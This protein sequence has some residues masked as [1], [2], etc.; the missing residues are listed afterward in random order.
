MNFAAITVCVTSQVFIVARV[1]YDPRFSVICEMVDLKEHL[2]CVK[3]SFKLGK[4]A[5]EMHEIMK[6]DFGD[7]A[8]GRTQ[9]FEWFSRFKH[10]ETSPDL[11]PC[12]F[13][14]YPR[15][16]SK[17]KGRRFQDITEIQEQSPTVLHAIKNVSFSVARNA[18]P[19]A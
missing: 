13:L 10:E 4:T 9:T 14:L 16:K 1:K 6:T 11:A 3:F 19:I 12:D 8:M 2:I 7:N 18:G 15:I 17:P 5:S